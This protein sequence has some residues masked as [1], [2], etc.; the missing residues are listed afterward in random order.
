V[1]VAYG[2][3][4]DRAHALEDVLDHIHDAAAPVD[5]HHAVCLAPFDPEV[6]GHVKSVRTQRANGLLPLF[7][8]VRTVPPRTGVKTQHLCLDRP[9]KIYNLVAWSPRLRLSRQH[10]NSRP[11]K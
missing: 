10:I 8:P 2:W 11:P 1:V 6:A 4:A 9:V 7:A 5:V 3:G